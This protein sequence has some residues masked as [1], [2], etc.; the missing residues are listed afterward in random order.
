MASGPLADRLRRDLE[1]VNKRLE[2]DPHDPRVLDVAA[3]EY[4]LIAAMALDEVDRL[5]ETIYVYY[6]NDRT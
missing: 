2:E 3:H 4:R 6:T 5:Q 1:R